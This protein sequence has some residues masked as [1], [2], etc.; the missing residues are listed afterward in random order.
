[1]MQK[2]RTKNPLKIRHVDRVV[3][4]YLKFGCVDMDVKKVHEAVMFAN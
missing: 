2:T 1:M 4:V 3:V